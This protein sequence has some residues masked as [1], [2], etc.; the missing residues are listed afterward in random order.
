MEYLEGV[1]KDQM[2]AQIFNNY[3]FTGFIGKGGYGQVFQARRHLDQLDYAVKIHSKRSRVMGTSNWVLRT[4]VDVLKVL[5]HPNIIK[6]VDYIETPKFIILVS[7]L[8]TAGDLRGFQDRFAKVTGTRCVPERIV[9]KI[10][11]Q[12]LEGV[13]YIHKRFMIHRDLKPGTR[14]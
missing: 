1:R 8:C 2:T 3:T 14:D 11:L 12:V 6:Y 13:S 9:A 7:E 5:S 10:V 4:E